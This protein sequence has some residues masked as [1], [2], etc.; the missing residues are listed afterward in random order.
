MVSDKFIL[1]LLVGVLVFFLIS[2]FIDISS[3]YN[4]EDEVNIDE[5]LPTKVYQ[6]SQCGVLTPISEIQMSGGIHCGC[7]GHRRL[8][9]WISRQQEV[10]MANRKYFNFVP[11][12]LNDSYGW[13]DAAFGSTGG[14]SNFNLD[15]NRRSDTIHYWG[16]FDGV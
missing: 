14:G 4:S 7:G 10:E 3:L 13:G 15:E 5:I 1:T 12:N 11:P 2:L 6:C 16:S 8:I 9:N